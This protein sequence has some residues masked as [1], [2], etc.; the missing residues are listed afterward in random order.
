MEEEAKAGEKYTEK[1]KKVEKEEEVEVEQK[2]GFF[3]MIT[4]FF[5]S[6]RPTIDET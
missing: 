5:S 3:S 4:N 2:G 1:E 6:G